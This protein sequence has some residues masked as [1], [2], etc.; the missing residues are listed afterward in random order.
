MSIKAIVTDIDGTLCSTQHGILPKTREALIEAQKSGIKLIL[1]SGR[2]TAGMKW[3]ADQ[4]NLSEYGGYL[5][6]YNGAEVVDYAT[7]KV[8]H[9]DLLTGE[10]AST[11]LKHAK[12][13]DLI[14]IIPTKDTLYGNKKDN[15]PFYF[16][17]MNQ[18]V[19]LLEQQAKAVQLELQLED[20]VSKVIDFPVYKVILAGEED[21]LKRYHQEI[22]APFQGKLNSVFSAAVFFEFMSK[23]VDKSTGVAKVFEKLNIDPKDTVA[24]GDNGNDLGMIK[25][26]GTGVA[27]HNAVPE[28]KDAA[29]IVTLSNN[30]NGI[31]FTLE[32]L[33]S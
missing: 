10:E 6:A 32:Q 15:M 19:Q 16:E 5:V 21:Y 24:F 22:A 30:E 9:D 14:P 4:L 1:A 28:L 25:Y 18:T 31:A 26:A 8:V 20:D 27:M 7:G 17:Q 11:V 2:P 13:F 3:F 12:N 23:N 29:D 33:L